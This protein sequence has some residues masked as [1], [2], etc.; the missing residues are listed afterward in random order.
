MSYCVIILEDNKID[1][2]LMKEFLMR[3]SEP[4]EEIHLV[5]NK[6]DY[7]A[8]LQELSVDLIIADYRLSGLNGT[9]AI[10]L[11]NELKPDV[12]IIIVSA[13][14]GEE[15]AVELIKAGASDFLI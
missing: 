5:F 4:F 10:E 15:K 6:S 11:K 1:A 8:A 9:D 3:S 2:Q 14:I 13:T 12:P 7:M